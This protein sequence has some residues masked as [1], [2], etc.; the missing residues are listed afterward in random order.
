MVRLLGVM[1]GYLGVNSLK[2]CSSSLRCFGYGPLDICT[3]ILLKCQ[4]LHSEVP[5]LGAGEEY[6]TENSLLTMPD[7]Q[8]GFRYQL[9]RSYDVSANHC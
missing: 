8:V 7:F 3:P 2:R 6:A 1:S 9:R 5:H 4:L